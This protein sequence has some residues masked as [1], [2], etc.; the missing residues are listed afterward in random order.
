LSQLLPHAPLTAPTGLIL[1]D[2]GYVA[3][4]VGFFRC[5]RLEGC[6]ARGLRRDA[7]NCRAGARRSRGI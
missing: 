5:D 4:A 1:R 6:V 7:S 2:R 3:T